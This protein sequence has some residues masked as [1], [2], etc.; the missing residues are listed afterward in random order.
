MSKF[1]FI[2]L[3]RGI[4]DYIDIKGSSIKVLNKFIRLGKREMY[5]VLNK[6]GISRKEF[7]AR[8]T[9]QKLTQYHLAKHFNPKRLKKYPE[10]LKRLKLNQKNEMESLKKIGLKYHYHYIDFSKGHC[11][12]EILYR[13][14]EGMDLKDIKRDLKLL[15]P[16]IT[17]KEQL[18]I[19]TY[20][21][22]VLPLPFSIEPNTNG[23]KPLID[24]E[25][26]P[27]ELY[28][29][30]DIEKMFLEKPILRDTS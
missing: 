18:E 15:E 21:D 10:L 29:L 26:E 8:I 2:G 5:D 9:A 20:M 1:K 17:P 12:Y 7:K 4:N 25:Y 14:N 28:E 19:D 27:N 11:E 13:Y 22:E 23:M 3:K 16:N 6:G 30:I 24:L